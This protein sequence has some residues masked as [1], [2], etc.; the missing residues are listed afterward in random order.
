MTKKIL[1]SLCSILSTAQPRGMIDCEIV[2]SEGQ[3]KFG[4]HSL[5]H[6]AASLFIEQG[7]TPKKI[8]VLLGHSSINMT[9]DV[10]G[11]LFHNPEED[12]AQMA[13]MESDL[14]AA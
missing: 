5:R 14:L 1:T 11:H 6:A 9:F 13:K 7:W 8:Q 4:F 2:D 3:P 10:Y 12:V